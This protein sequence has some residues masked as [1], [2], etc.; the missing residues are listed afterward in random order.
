M[1][2]P[3]TMPS[4]SFP[5]EFARFVDFVGPQNLHEAVSRVASKLQRLSPPI[6][7][8]YRDRYFFHQQCISITDGP[9]P[10]QLDVENVYA[11]RAATF[12]AGVNRVRDSLSATAR[13]RFRNVILGG[14]KPDRDIRQLEHEIRSFVHFGQKAME[15]GFADLEGNGRFDLSCKAGEVAFDV[16]CKTVT[17]DTGASIRTDLLANLSEEFRLAINRSSVATDFGIFVLTFKKHPD[18]CHNV[19][20]RLREALTSSSFAQIN[21]ED[22][23]LVFVPKLEWTALLLSAPS[24]ELR[25]AINRDLVGVS[26]KNFAMRM[27][28]KILGLALQPHKPNSLSEKVIN[29]LKEGADQCSRQC[30]SLVWLHFIGHPEEEFLRVANF[31]QQGQG[32]GLNAIVASALHPRASTTDRSHV[33]TIRFSAEAAAITRKPVLDSEL[34]LQKADSLSGPCYDVPN[35][36]CRFKNDIDF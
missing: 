1:N 6:R 21:S 8:L 12:M 16:E 28:N 11:L 10:F 7:E 32:A 9:N 15:I 17:E 3:F 24:D 2:T 5:V 34:L 30:P 36:F 19:A 20:P 31:S 26:L 35:P 14:L 25:S 27:G 13:P 4:T 23:D 22:F 18:Q 33:H 29:V